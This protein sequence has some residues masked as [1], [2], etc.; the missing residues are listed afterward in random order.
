MHV[1]TIADPSSHGIC[2]HAP[3]AGASPS[4]G[5]VMLRF[6]SQ[7]VHHTSMRV[8]TCTAEGMLISKVYLVSRVLAG[9]AF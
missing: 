8:L 6:M 2:L 1:N 3:Y 5:A 9:G 4:A 7:H